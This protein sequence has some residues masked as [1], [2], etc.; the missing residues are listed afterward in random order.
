M[1][2]RSQL[3]YYAKERYRFLFMMILYA[4][5]NIGNRSDSQMIGRIEIWDTAIKVATLRGFT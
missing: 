3:A 1:N 2:S 4:L 5:G